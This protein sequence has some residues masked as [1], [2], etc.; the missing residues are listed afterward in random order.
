M[1]EQPIDVGQGQLLKVLVRPVRHVTRMERRYGLPTPLAEQ[2]ARLPRSEEV[3]AVLDLRLAQKRERAARAGVGL[4]SQPI[5]AGVRRIRSSK[6]RLGV[7]RFA[8]RE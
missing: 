4:S 2:L 3:V 6:H 5:Y 1:D 7:L 8:D